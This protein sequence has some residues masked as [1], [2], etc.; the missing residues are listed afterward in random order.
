M[1]KGRRL[2]GA[3][4]ALL[5]AA[6]IDRVHGARLDAGDV[7]ENAAAGLVAAA[8]TGMGIA[9]RAPHAGRC[10]LYALERG[11]VRVDAEIIDRINRIDEAVTVATLQ[12]LSAARKGAVVATVKI[13]PLAVERT[14]VDACVAAAGAGQG[15]GPAAFPAQARGADRYRTARRAVAQLCCG[16]YQQPA[17]H[18]RTRQPS[19]PG[20]ALRPRHRSRGRRPARTARGRQRTDHDFRHHGSQ[21]PCRHGSRRHS[22][23]RRRDRPFRHAGGAGQ[24]VAAGAP[25]RSAGHHPAGLR[26][27]ATH[28]RPRLGPAAHAGR[29]A[30]G[31]RADHGHGRRRPDPQPGRGRRRREPPCSR[32][33]RGSRRGAASP[34]WCWRPAAAAAWAAPTSCCSVCKACRC[35]AGW[36]MRRWP[37]VAPRFGSSPVLPRRMPRPA[38]P[39]STLPSRTTP[40]SDRHGVVLAPRPRGAGP[41][42]RC[43]GG[44]AGRHALH[45]R[46]PHRSP[47]RRLRS[48]AAGIVT[49]AKDGRRGNP[50]LWPRAH[51]AEMQ[52]VEGDTGAREL[53]QRHAG[54]VQAVACD[55]DAIFADIDTPAALGEVA[56]R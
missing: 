49:L 35:C 32:S 39:G 40:I 37:R 16:G 4:L 9:A 15:A 3:D 19:R 26:P 23:R 17:A 5:A 51:F 50:V 7:D 36:S 53:L 31:A 52:A 33:R 8:L 18:G 12:P 46:W 47:D 25:G 29:S 24:H 14:L 20:A 42:G 45:R 21:G 30:R 10:N 13:I 43:R 34:R 6:G 38:S 54:Q 41:G 56:G 28:E 48:R 22:R 44:A 2:T 27:L 1:K 55:D 11:L